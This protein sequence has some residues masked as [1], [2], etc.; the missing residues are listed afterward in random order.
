MAKKQKAVAKKRVVA[1]AGTGRS[2]SLGQAAMLN[3]AAANGEITLIAIQD[4]YKLLPAAQYV[5]GCDW[6]WWNYHYANVLIAPRTQGQMLL[7]ADP[8]ARE[9][10]DQLG[11]VQAEDWDKPKAG[12]ATLPGE[13]RTGFSSG[14]QALHLAHNMEP[15]VILLCGLDYA[16]D[17]WFGPHPAEITTT[18]SWFGKM[19]EA[20]NVLAADIDKVGRTKVYNCSDSSALTCFEKM[21]LSQ[22]L[23]LTSGDGEVDTQ[24]SSEGE[25][26]LVREDVSIL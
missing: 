6:Q 7:C 11:L 2:L 18:P 1:V 26:A 17:H 3:H 10:F 5:Y 20:M 12:L 21:P 19:I 13:I 8:H 25:P 14:H 22:A 23:A 24:S 15:D 9:Q 4:N 16:G